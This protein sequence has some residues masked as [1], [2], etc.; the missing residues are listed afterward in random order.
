MLK[1]ALENIMSEDVI[2]IKNNATIGQVAHIL[3]RHRINGILVVSKDDPNEIVGIVTTTDL[4]RLLD[5]ILSQQGNRMAELE[6]VGDMP[7]ASVL[8]TN[9]VRVSK[10]TKI[11]K[12]I[13]LMYKENKHT[14]PVFDDEKLV[15]IIGRHDILNTAFG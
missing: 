2:S 3:L 4:L 9:V 10:N 11:E 8:T 6:V 13:A 1:T 15:G 5:D 12:V 14:I 7:V